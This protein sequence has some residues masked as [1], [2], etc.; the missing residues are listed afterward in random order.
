MD[1]EEGSHSI[2]DVDEIELNQLTNYLITLLRQPTSQTPLV[3]V[4]EPTYS[5]KAEET[6]SDVPEELESHPIVWKRSRY[7]R[8]PYKRHNQYV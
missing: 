3:I 4:D 6:N 1:T 5:Q 2:D 8:Y 7:W